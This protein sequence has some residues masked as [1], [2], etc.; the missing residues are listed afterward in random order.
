[1][2]LG[3]WEGM[4]AP[5]ETRKASLSLCSWL[6]PNTDTHNFY[7]ER[8]VLLRLHRNFNMW[9]AKSKVAQHGRGAQQA[10]NREG[11]NW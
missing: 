7:V 8:F 9:S 5:L 1:M 11:Q 3:D 6:K 4:R 2:V 10:G